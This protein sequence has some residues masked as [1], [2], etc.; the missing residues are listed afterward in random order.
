M[1]R[2]YAS[3]VRVIPG[4]HP[5][6]I[7]RLNVMFI[8]PFRLLMLVAHFTALICASLGSD[9]MI[10]EASLGPE[11][12]KDEYLYFRRSTD[13]CLAASFLFLFFDCWG[14]VTARTLRS[15]LMNTINGCLHA[16]AAVL[17]IVA[18][19]ATMHVTRIWQIFY[20]FSIIPTG[21]EVIALCI[22]YNNGMDNFY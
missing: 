12:T 16:A 10:L 19:N 18:W 15:G 5:T 21:L 4:F 1:Y 2:V 6:F 22:S 13:A 17:L 9:E 11:Y 3:K 8:I 14:I 20:I 7:R